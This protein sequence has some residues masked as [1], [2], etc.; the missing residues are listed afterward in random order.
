MP[1]GVILYGPPG[2]GK[3]T[4]TRELGRISPDF[5]L[6]RRLKAGPGRSSGYRITTVGEIDRLS[7]SGALLYRN[8]RYGAEYAIDR[9]GLT[10][11]LINGQVPVLHMGQM[12]GVSALT[13]FPI[14][15]TKVLLW[16]PRAVTNERCKGRGDS[17]LEARLKVWEETREDLLAHTQSTWTLTI[18][19][20]KQVPAEAAQS[21]FDAVATGKVVTPQDI[22]GLVRE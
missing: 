8:A 11:L 9:P 2:S 17:D 3:D 12:A 22:A 5:A 4:I 13:D 1:P 6:F 16:C 19:T 18:A 10:E 15:W 7:D 14:E 20:D 21:I